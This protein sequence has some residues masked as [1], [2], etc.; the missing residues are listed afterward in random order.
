LNLILK[1]HAQSIGISS[2]NA[3][4]LLSAMG[5]AN[6][7]GRVI[8]GKI[9]DIILDKLGDEYIIFVSCIMMTISGLCKFVFPHFSFSCSFLFQQSS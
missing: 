2:E 9:A 3:S 8:S 5:I 6:C 7:L 4:L 1:D